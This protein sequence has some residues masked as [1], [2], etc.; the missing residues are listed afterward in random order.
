MT[1][2]VVL[3]LFVLTLGGCANSLPERL[4]VK[5]TD[6]VNNSWTNT[7]R[8]LERSISRIAQGPEAFDNRASQQLEEYCDKDAG[9]HVQA[10]DP[11]LGKGPM[12]F[13][14]ATQ[15][16]STRYDAPQL[17]G[18]VNGQWEVWQRQTSFKS[19]YVMFR[20]TETRLSHGRSARPVAY[21]VNYVAAD[22]DGQF[23]GS[24]QCADITLA[25][26]VKAG[27]TAR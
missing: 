13:T 2:L 7:E 17:L 11:A 26:L 9:I 4:A 8:F 23:S 21:A 6:G 19:E 10:V 25:A 14:P 16:S 15:R 18:W 12:Q 24:L 5:L 3:S 20:R 1:R 22:K 27:A